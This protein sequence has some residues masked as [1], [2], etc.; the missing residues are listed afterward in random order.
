MTSRY[1]A[2]SDLCTSL[3][4]AA[5]KPNAMSPITRSLSLFSLTASLAGFADAVRAASL[6]G[7]PDDF[8]RLMDVESSAGNRRPSPHAAR[9][10]FGGPASQR[11]AGRCSEAMA[12]SVGRRIA[13]A[14]AALLG[15]L[16]A[17]AVAAP[18]LVDVEAYKTLLL[19]A[20]E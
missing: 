4:G 1:S 17:A 2:W 19:Q 8:G 16:L 12:M 6:A 15:P 13:W 5:W 10:W 7:S 20:G 14:V 11:P 3:A 9:S 18:W